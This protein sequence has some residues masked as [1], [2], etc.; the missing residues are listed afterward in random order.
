MSKLR[1]SITPELKEMI[2]VELGEL[3]NFGTTLKED[4]KGYAERIVPAI[5]E[6]AES[7]PKDE[8]RNLEH[9]KAQALLIAGMTALA[10]KKQ[11]L[12]RAV[13]IVAKTLRIVLAAV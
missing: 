1:R 9:L 11:A 8:R 5:I 3:L 4:L 7:D 2:S 6:F 10:A 12:E 13:T